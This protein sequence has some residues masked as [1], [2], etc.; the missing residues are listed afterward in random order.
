MIY[1][2]LIA[3]AIKNESYYF[4]QFEN[5]NIMFSS[6]YEDAMNFYNLNDKEIQYYLDLITYNIW[7]KTVTC[8]INPQNI[9][10]FEIIHFSISINIEKIEYQNND[11][12]IRKAISKLSNKE[13]ELLGLEDYGLLY[14]LQSDE[15]DNVAKY[16]FFSNNLLSCFRSYNSDP[17][18]LEDKITNSVKGKLK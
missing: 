11:F 3:I 13:I 18:T 17:V 5:D 16:D 8:N 2:K 7:K 15:D 1:Y 6:N 12:D 10:K 9:D 14:K 4:K